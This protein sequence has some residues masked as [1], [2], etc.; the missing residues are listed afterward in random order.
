MNVL[1]PNIHHT[2]TSQSCSI[3]CGN[4]LNMVVKLQ[5]NRNL[6]KPYFMTEFYIGLILYSGASRPHLVESDFTVSVVYSTSGVLTGYS[7]SSSDVHSLHSL[8]L[9]DKHSRQPSTLSS[10][11]LYT[12]VSCALSG[13]SVSSLVRSTIMVLNVCFTPVRL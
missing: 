13:E 1:K 10:S 7:A 8:Q 12:V 5:K 3:I 2:C 9:S 4:I 6:I 11:E